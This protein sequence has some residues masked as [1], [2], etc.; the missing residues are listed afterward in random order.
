LLGSICDSALARV[1]G[2]HAHLV[3]SQGVWARSS[4]LFLAVGVRCLAFL[5]ESL[6]LRSGMPL[7]VSN[8]HQMKGEESTRV[9]LNNVGI[10]PGAMPASD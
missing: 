5:V 6:D 8:S 3:Q 7:R 1:I 4:I 2:R 10:L 9:A